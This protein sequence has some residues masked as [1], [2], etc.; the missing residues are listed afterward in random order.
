MRQHGLI[1][2]STATH[3]SMSIKIVYIVFLFF[4]L[5]LY[6]N[7]F[8]NPPTVNI[9]PSCD[10]GLLYS[11]T[12]HMTVLWEMVLQCLF[13]RHCY[14]KP[15]RE[16][17]TLTIYW[18]TR[19]P[20]LLLYILA[21]LLF[22]TWPMQEIYTLFLIQHLCLS[23]SMLWWGGLWIQPV[24]HCPVYW[25]PYRWLSSRMGLSLWPGRWRC[26]TPVVWS[27]PLQ[28]TCQGPVD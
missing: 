1:I 14:P 23:L 2:D 3:A 20:V 21:W 26:K 13:T 4:L 24:R 28:G 11:H 27:Q 12:F 15:L 18:N 17:S 19:Y 7:L 10:I 16:L 5:K 22:S 25:W 9:K 8:Y 6:C